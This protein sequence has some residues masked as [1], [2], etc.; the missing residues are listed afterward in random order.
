MIINN[1]NIHQ[2]K[3]VIEGT[4]VTVGEI[5]SALSRGWSI[6]KII[7]NAQ[8]SGT[9]LLREEVIEAIRFAEA[10]LEERG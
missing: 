1:P 4:R 5:L 8:L 2:G 9:N 3:P 7:K 6:N 10:K